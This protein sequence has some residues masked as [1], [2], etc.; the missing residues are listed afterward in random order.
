MAQILLGFDEIEDGLP[1][2]CVRCGDRA[3]VFKDHVF[4][5]TPQWIGLTAFFLPLT[6]ALAIAL[7]KRVKVPV[8][9]CER[10]QNHWRWR[11]QVTLLGAAVLVPLLGLGILLLWIFA[12]DDRVAPVILYGLL[13][14]LVLLG[15]WLITVAALYTTVLRPVDVTERS[16]TL[17][18]VSQAFVR[19]MYDAREDEDDDE[20][21]DDDPRPRRRPRR[22][23]R[24]HDP[25]AR[26]RRRLPPDAYRKE[27]W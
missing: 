11:L 6:I 4:T 1:P 23:D 20:Y 5:W 8:P 21:E 14:W 25:E 27:N 19:A 26:R 18:G 15:A 3:T 13:G 24:V 2:V 7:R 17:A 12:N 9:F 10:H 22:S 16:I